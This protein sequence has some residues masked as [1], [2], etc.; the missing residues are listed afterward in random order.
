MHSTYPTRS[1]SIDTDGA[2]Q[3]IRRTANGGIDYQYYMALGARERSRAVKALASDLG[4]V[5]TRMF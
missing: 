2:E 3:P 4:R 5:F 1:T